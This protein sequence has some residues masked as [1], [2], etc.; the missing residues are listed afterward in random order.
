MAVS[1]ASSPS[2]AAAHAATAD[3]TALPTSS[4]PNQSSLAP[5]SR[6]V[7]VTD[8]SKR[9]PADSASLTHPGSLT[10]SCP[11][12]DMASRP[13]DVTKPSGEDHLTGAHEQSMLASR[14]ALYSPGLIR[15]RS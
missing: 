4:G 15:A 10:A 3:W 8:G 9:R 1:S 13:G 2:T 6:I 11:S 5:A 12:N 14:H 7:S